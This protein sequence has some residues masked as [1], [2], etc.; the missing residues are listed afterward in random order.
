MILFIFLVAPHSCKPTLEECDVMDEKN[1]ESNIS[2]YNNYD[3]N[4]DSNSCNIDSDVTSTT[5]ANDHGDTDNESR[6]S[7]SYIP[8]SDNEDE[9]YYDA[10]DEELAMYRLVDDVR[11]N[12]SAV[13]NDDDDDSLFCFRVKSDQTIYSLESAL[14]I[15]QQRPKLTDRLYCQEDSD[16]CFRE[17]EYDVIDTDDDADVVEV[18]NDTTNNPNT[19]RLEIKVRAQTL[20]DEGRLIEVKTTPVHDKNKLKIGKVRSLP[21]IRFPIRNGKSKYYRSTSE[22]SLASCKS[23]QKLDSSVY[24]EYLLRKDCPTCVTPGKSGRSESDGQ[25]GHNTSDADYLTT[26]N[27]CY[28]ADSHPDTNIETQAEDA[29]PTKFLSLLKIGKR[30]R[31]PVSNFDFSS[32]LLLNGGSLNGRFQV[33]TVDEVATLENE[34]NTQTFLFEKSK[35]D[36][37]LSFLP[38]EV[39][40]SHELKTTLLNGSV[41]HTFLRSY[42]IL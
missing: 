10:D 4:N 30:K 36:C 39:K 27:K 42:E 12:N 9:E 18:I 37:S 32:P 14:E 22:L 1:V 13:N 34:A 5:I 24:D 38:L 6:I 11:N 41:E 25:I 15:I 35:N 19:S 2:C 20:N 8:T 28:S 33:T 7:S 31:R 17:S 29:P 3:D 21:S 23:Q 26:I 40:R 16:D